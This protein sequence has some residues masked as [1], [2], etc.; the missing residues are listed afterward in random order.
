MITT[1]W[2][3]TNIASG[4]AGAISYTTG[5]SI[6]ESLEYSS[7]AAIY[8]EVKLVRAL[9]FLTPVLPYGYTDG[10]YS[11]IVY[12]RPAPIYAGSDIRYNSTTASTSSI[13]AIIGLPNLRIFQPFFA[14][15]NMQIPAYIPRGLEHA[16]LSADAP[17]VPTPY[18]GSPGILTVASVGLSNSTTY[19]NVIVRAT[20]HLRG[21]H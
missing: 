15:P 20:Y 10:S 14:R 21:R 1:G 19:F 11:T 13:S 18:A 17:T 9:F 12:E 16:L 2:V 4:T 5:L 3:A 6:Q 8:S 7:L